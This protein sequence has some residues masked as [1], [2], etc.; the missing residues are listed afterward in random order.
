M[1]TL[2]KKVSISNLQNVFIQMGKS[3]PKE[4][5]VNVGIATTES[6][7][8]PHTNQEAVFLF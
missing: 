5:C 1:L 8:G 3:V 7:M 4:C 6:I 2:I